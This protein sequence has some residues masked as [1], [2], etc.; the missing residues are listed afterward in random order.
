M[1]PDTF[2]HPLD[3]DDAIED[4]DDTGGSD[5]VVELLTAA[6]ADP[7]ARGDE[8][9]PEYVDQL[10]TASCE[11]GHERD[12]IDT[13]RRLAQVEPGLADFVAS[14][15]IELHAELGEQDIAEGL[16]TRHYAEQRSR[17]SAER[18]LQ[19]YAS[20]AATAAEQLDDRELAHT[21]ATEGLALARKH[22]DSQDVAMIQEVLAQVAPSPV[23]TVGGPRPPGMRAGWQRRVAYRLAY[24]PE[25]EYATA[26]AR[27]LLDA[28]MP[29]LHED[30]RR[31]VQ[32]ALE[33]LHLGPG[34]DAYVVPLDVDGLLAYAEREGKDPASRRTRMDY[35]N[36]LDDGRDIPWP[37]ERNAVCWCGYGRKYKKCCGRPGFSLVEVPDRAST[38]LRIS[39]DGARPEVWRRVAV[40]STI[41]L[42]RL[43]QVIQDAMGWANAHRYQF[44]DGSTSILDPRANRPEL[45]ADTQRLIS[46]ANEPGISFIYVYDFGDYWSHTVT[47]EEIREA[48]TANEVEMLDGA[49]ACP[50]E[51]CGGVP[52][53]QALLDAL[54]DPADPRHEEAVDLLGKDLDPTA[55][56]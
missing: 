51:D 24:L 38:I 22:G 4:A 49:G 47:V 39:L 53:Y 50:P 8:R 25:P 42:D 55:P 41:R 52:G 31:S 10:V 9:L 7:R 1:L 43:H 32:G 12:A 26:M 29:T 28:T 23:A 44:I 35:N 46:M 37:P 33:D 40:P 3:L 30:Y 45:K 11:A 6:L 34:E 54:A 19:F 15:V 56:V 21:L 27:H 17:P 14:L 16:L 13:L 18:S 48:G 36:W 2:F 5:A 20:A